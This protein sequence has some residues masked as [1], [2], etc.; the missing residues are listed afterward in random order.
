LVP[1]YRF[2]GE[3][4]VAL[5][6]RLLPRT[7]LAWPRALPKGGRAAPACCMLRDVVSYGVPPKEN[8]KNLS[9]TPLLTHMRTRGMTGRI[10]AAVRVAWAA[11]AVAADAVRTG[12]CF[13]R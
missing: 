4:G 10:S 12:V 6:C 11:D 8:E 5:V 13:I 2:S 9:A 1:L 3:R 7:R